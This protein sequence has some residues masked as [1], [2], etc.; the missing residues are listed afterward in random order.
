MSETVNKLQ[1]EDSSSS[2]PSGVGLLP[3][4]LSLIEH[5]KVDLH[6]EVGTCQLPVSELFK[7]K[8]GNTLTLDQ[9]VDQPMTVLLNGKAIAK[10]QLVAAGDQYGIYITH[11]L[12]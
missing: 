2:S 11:I 12:D 6:I 8:S 7:L 1:L 3:Q 4:D 5:V 9:D 10:G